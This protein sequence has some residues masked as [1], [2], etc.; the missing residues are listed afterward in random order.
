MSICSTF[1]AESGIVTYAAVRN[2]VTTGLHHRIVI[3]ATDTNGNTNTQDVT[4]EVRDAAAVIITDSVA[5]DYASIADGDLTFSFTFS[6]PIGAGEC[7]RRVRPRRHQRDR[8]RPPPSTLT[9]ITAD[10][11][12]TLVV[13]PDSRHQ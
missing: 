3:T 10:V 9:E 2:V 7:H 5:G 11:R 12:Y 13:T 1:A 8:W 6:E 4:I